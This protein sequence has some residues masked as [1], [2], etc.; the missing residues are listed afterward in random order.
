MRSVMGQGSAGFAT[1]WL[2]GRRCPTRR[3]ESAQTPQE[4]RSG[5]MGAHGHRR[6]QG[7]SRVLNR[8]LS[9]VINRTGLVLDLV[10]EM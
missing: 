1:A 2:R 5:S 9:T 7:R 8:W 10:L 6:Y 4:S 3:F